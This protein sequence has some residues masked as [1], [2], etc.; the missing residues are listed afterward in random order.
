MRDSMKLSTKLSTLG[1]AS[2]D[3]EESIALRRRS[4]ESL[5]D[6]GDDG[7]NLLDVSNLQG[8]G[9]SDMMVDGGREAWK[10]L[11]AAWLIDFMTSG[12]RLRVQ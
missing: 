6:L 7:D 9:Q 12:K 11:F 10:T 4:T 3:P 2:L 8:L 1:E 5:S